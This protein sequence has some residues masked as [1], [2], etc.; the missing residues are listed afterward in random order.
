MNSTFTFD[1]DAE[2]RSPLTLWPLI[3][4][5]FLFFHVIFFSLAQLKK[6]IGRPFLVKVRKPDCQLQKNTYAY[7]VSDTLR[8]RYFA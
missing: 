1:F 8:A 3:L 5:L 7:H 6:I 2:T 4:I